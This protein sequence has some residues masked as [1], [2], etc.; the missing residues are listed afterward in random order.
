MFMDVC[1]GLTESHIVLRKL[2]Q[3]VWGNYWWTISWTTLGVHAQLS[4]YCGA[5]DVC[6]AAAANKYIQH[7]GFYFKIIYLHIIGMKTGWYICDGTGQFPYRNI[8]S[9]QKPLFQTWTK[10]I[11]ILVNKYISDMSLYWNVLLYIKY[12]TISFLFLFVL[13]LYTK[14]PKYTDISLKSSGGIFFLTHRKGSFSSLFLQNITKQTHKRH[15][16]KDLEQDE[17]TLD[18]LQHHKNVLMVFR[19]SLN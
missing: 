2:I 5:P 11:N 6:L 19:F 18:I 7:R 14:Y 12:N 3:T 13:F 8:Q 9:I 4:R 16:E 15:K 10:W 1:W 17:I